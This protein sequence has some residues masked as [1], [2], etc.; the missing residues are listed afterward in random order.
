MESKNYTAA[1][2]MLEKSASAIPHYKTYESI[3]ECYVE[4]RKPI[5]AVLFFAAAAGIGN[6]QFRSFF[7]LGRTLFEIGE[8]EGAREKLRNAISLNP[9]YKEA[10]DLLE[11]IQ[12]E[13]S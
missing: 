10:R 6:R 3:G 5:N 9:N 8:V 12:G 1:I 2:D 13:V 11:S 4:L 7:L